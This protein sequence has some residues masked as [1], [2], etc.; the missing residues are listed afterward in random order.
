MR[1]RRSAALDIGSWRVLRWL[2][3]YPF[4]R[5]NDLVIALAPWERRSAVYQRLAKLTRLHLIEAIHLVGWPG[6]LYHLSP[7]GRAVCAGHTG[8]LAHRP[9]SP[10]ERDQLVRLLPRLP[11]LLLIQDLVNG[12][13]TGTARALAEQGHQARMIQW[14]WGRDY[15]H[16][17]PSQGSSAL[18]LT[19]RADGAL[20]L[21]LFPS[22]GAPT[23]I[24]YSFLLLHCPL[25]DVRVFRQRLDRIVRW[26]EAEAW[27]P[28]RQMPP[29]LI[30][31]ATPRQA[32]WW[33]LAASQV[34]RRLHVNE[35]V[36][37]V[38]C[39]PA[40]Q[41]LAES[42]RLPWRRLGTASVCHLQDLLHPAT[43]TAFPELAFAVTA[44]QRTHQEAA[45]PHLVTLST[46][47]S[48][49][50]M[51]LSRREPVTDE[52]VLTLRLH[53]AHWRLLQLCFAH[54]LLCQEHLVH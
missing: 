53:P 9:V 23:P 51:A 43:E 44:D 29:V 52:C 36:G 13:V 15:Q 11:V 49:G 40:N 38:A 35:L 5:G 6:G 19:M 3:L 48:Y 4:Q 30:L 32:E 34:A 27:T 21:R 50:V 14:N 18:D 22:S 10:Q 39:W 37:A 33:H 24:W 1:K 54:P 16:R 31:A 47:R 20:A 12:L 8:P 42:W 41:P 7:L 2:D 46:R 26:R 28:V 45:I 17:F 25:D